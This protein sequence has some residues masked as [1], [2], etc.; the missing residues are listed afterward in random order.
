MLIDAHFTSNVIVPFN[1][2]INLFFPVQCKK[3]HICW[4]GSSL[5]EA[6]LHSLNHTYVHTIDLELRE[7]GKPCFLMLSH[8]ILSSTVKEKKLL[9]HEFIKAEKFQPDWNSLCLRKYT[10]RFVSTKNHHFIRCSFNI[11][12]VCFCHTRATS[13]EISRNNFF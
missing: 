1:P 7:F 8:E 9:S 5:F 4:H 10:V 2:K 3:T 11:L 13:R 6:K 12:H